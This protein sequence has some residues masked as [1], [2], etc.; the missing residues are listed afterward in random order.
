MKLFIAFILVIAALLVIYYFF[1]PRVIRIIMEPDDKK[2]FKTILAVVG[3]KKWYVFN[4]DYITHYDDMVIID[5]T[6][7]NIAFS[8]LCTPLSNIQNIK[9]M[10]AK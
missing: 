6:L 4:V 1:R 5:L 10:E 9:V 2:S 7:P 8:K 3:S